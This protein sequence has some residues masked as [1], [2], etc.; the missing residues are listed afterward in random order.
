MKK[1]NSL[2]WLLASF[3]IVFSGCSDDDPM[4]SPNIVR[5]DL[6]GFDLSDGIATAGGK[7][8]KDTYESDCNV[9]S[10]VFRFSHFGYSDYNFWDGFTVSNSNDNSEQADFL[11]NQFAAMAKGGVAGE[12][13]PY[14][15]VYSGEGMRPD[16]GEFAENRYTSWVKIN[17]EE[18]SYK[19]IGAYVCN[20]SWPYYN[21]TKGDGFAR[22]FA[23][24]DYFKLKAYGVDKENNISEPVEFY[25]ADYRSA[26]ESKW[27]INNKWEWMDLSALGEVEYII[28]RLET[29]DKAN[30]Y[31]NTALY[32]CLD[33][34]TVEKID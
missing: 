16:N 3:L 28:F 10:Q 15:V 23:Q 2:L 18:N 20:H 12:S 26:D 9:E 29:T 11:T 8:W 5:L 4:E 7:F 21:I 31:S 14:M 32:F 13:T 30:G 17:D 6:S 22:K 25:L 1:I 34:L 33:R 27:S 24:G 19:A